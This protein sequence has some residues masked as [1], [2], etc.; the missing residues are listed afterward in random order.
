ML[1]QGKQTRVWTRMRRA[2]WHVG[3]YQ[4]IGRWSLVCIT[5][6][7][8]KGSIVN[9]VTARH[10]LISQSDQF[11]NFTHV[12][13]SNIGRDF[14][15]AITPKP[16]VTVSR[17]APNALGQ[18][19][20][21]GDQSGNNYATEIA[22]FPN[23]AAS[24][25]TYGNGVNH[26]L[27][28]NGRQMPQQ[29]RDNNVASFEYQYD[30]N[31]NVTTIYDQQRGVGYN[32]QMGYDGLDRLVE[33]GSGQF[34]GDSWNR[35]TYDVLD[36][37]L[38]AQLA[39]VSE[40]NYW[41]DAKN[42]LTNVVSN[43]GATTVGLSYDPQGNLNNKNGQA[44]TF[45]YGNRLRDVTGKE[46]YAYD[47]YGRRTVAGGPTTLT[48]Q[49]HTQAGQ[50][51]YTEA[52]GKGGV[53]YIYLNGSLLATRNAGAIKFQH[54]GRSQDSSATHDLKAAISAS[55]ASLG[56]FQPSVWR[57]RVFISKAM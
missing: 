18:A 2:D 13:R 19:T 33:A 14:K 39:G 28:L 15:I 29:V 3:N 26:A 40:K 49:I 48:P 36:N 7:V 1:T 17:I 46:S 32:R 38:S 10:E 50:L 27:V 11:V 56:V 12:T 47:A 20:A 55:I 6:K 45:D 34:G 23:G 9:P 41:Y 30:A 57:G 37:I 16:M 53:E 8:F 24:Q 25:F 4:P 43:A 35:Y 44:F 22:Y 5:E 42:R 51:F 54:T 52:S 21:V 31:G